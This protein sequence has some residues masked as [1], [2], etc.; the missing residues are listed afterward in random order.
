M[1]CVVE[2][3]SFMKKPDTLLSCFM[4]YMC[5]FIEQEEKSWVL[6]YL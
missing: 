1:N 4:M 2:L 3:N 6:V 5:L